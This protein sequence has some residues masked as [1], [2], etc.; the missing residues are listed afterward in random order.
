M[1]SRCEE[2]RTLWT[3]WHDGRLDPETAERCAAERTRCPSCARY[4]RQMRE[5]V[6]ALGELPLPDRQSHN[7]RTHSARPRAHRTRTL[8]T[9]AA[10]VMAFAAGMLLAPLQTESQGSTV[11]R[12]EAVQLQPQQT[13]QIQ[14]AVAAPRTMDE[15]QFTIELPDGVEL[16][17][18]PG[19][20]VVGW[21]GR[22]SEGRNRLTLPVRVTRNTADGD[23]IARIRH[24]EGGSELR[25]PLKTTGASS[26][27]RS[28]M[29]LS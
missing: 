20:R 16:E 9:A 25:V 17:G 29:N 26:S 11:I 23:L 24:A 2:F 15:V 4:D 28:I 8:A 1:N 13:K 12:A 7:L 19:Q 14:V 5:L 21:Q 27:V 6:H 22:L 10:I 3:E 18:Y